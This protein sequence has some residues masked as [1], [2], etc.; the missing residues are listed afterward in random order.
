MKK[1]YGS[2]NL[3]IDLMGTETVVGP[4]LHPYNMVDFRPDD[5]KF[6]IKD[7]AN[8][9]SKQCRYIGNTNDFYSVAQHCV[10]M[11]RT[12]LLLGE[13]GKAYQALMHD[14]AEAYLGDISSPI[15]SVLPEYKKMESHI[16]SQLFKHYS[17]SDICKDIKSVD[18]NISQ[19]EMAFM[20][21][22][23]YDEYAFSDYWKP[24]KAKLLFL[25]TY[26][27]IRYLAKLFAWKTM[28]KFNYF[29]PQKAEE[30]ISNQIPPYSIPVIMNKE[31]EP[32]LEP[33]VL[34]DKQVHQMAGRVYGLKKD[35]EIMC[36]VNSGI[37]TFKD[38]I[39]DD[40]K[41]IRF[42]SKGAERKPG[43]EYMVGDI[44]NDF[45]INESLILIQQ[46]DML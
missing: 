5:Y 23:Q 38:Y 25:Q 46:Y 41:Y 45:D 36:I 17:V 30:D 27:Q 31:K 33:C 22:S 19:F 18:F 15:K 42:D 14:I 39:K 29:D 28:I 34:M 12:F 10:M 2:Q 4:G 13:V 44:T 20:M 1:L 9:L 16:E 21:C 8:S 7:I 3:D 6:N 37:E 26:T 40:I 43:P 35:D 32:L 11:A 24:K